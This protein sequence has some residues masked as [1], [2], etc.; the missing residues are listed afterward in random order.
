M[1]NITLLIFLGF[2]SNYVNS[3]NISS[4]NHLQIESITFHSKQESIYPSFKGVVLIKVIDN[5]AWSPSSSCSNNYVAIRNE[6]NHL[7]SAALTA[8]A[9]SQSIKLY[10]DEIVVPSGNYCFLRALQ[11]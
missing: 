10:S 9:S 5:I 2:F 7:I 11:F 3:A 1:K 6:D 4:S 8:Y